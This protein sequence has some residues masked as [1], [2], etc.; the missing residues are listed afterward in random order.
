[1]VER[2]SRV[3]FSC[4][5]SSNRQY[6]W[7]VESLDL[8]SDQ[9]TEFLFGEEGKSLNLFSGSV[10]SPEDR[11]NINTNRSR[12]RFNYHKTGRDISNVPAT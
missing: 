11:N 12:V 8:G 3:H 7:I 1:M 6:N 2:I 9:G 10:P 5:V 4:I